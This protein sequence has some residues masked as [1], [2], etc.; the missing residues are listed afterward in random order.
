MTKHFLAPSFTSTIFPEDNSSLHGFLIHGFSTS[1][2]IIH[3]KKEKGKKR[4]TEG[5]FH[6]AI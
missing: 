5:G 4:K 3:E 2:A 1:M 6:D